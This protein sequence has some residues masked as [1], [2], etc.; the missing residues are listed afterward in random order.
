MNG[1]YYSPHHPDKGYEGEIP[2]LKC[3]CVCR[4]PKPEMLLQ[5]AEDFNINLSESWMVGYGENDICA[6]KNVGCRTVLLGKKNYGQDV[7][8]ENLREVVRKI[9][10][11]KA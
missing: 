9:F 6:G 10:Y 5:A 3:V 11:G 7:A 4:K 8:G 1:I 2:K